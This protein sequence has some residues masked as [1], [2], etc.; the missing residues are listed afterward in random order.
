M[1]LNDSIPRDNGTVYH[2]KA[3]PDVQ[4]LRGWKVLEDFVQFDSSRDVGQGGR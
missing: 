2:D 3:R 4:G 1:V